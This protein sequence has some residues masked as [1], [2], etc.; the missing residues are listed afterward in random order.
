MIGQ[1]KHPCILAKQINVKSAGCL[2]NITWQ[3]PDRHSAFLK[4]WGY[5]T[6]FRRRTAGSSGG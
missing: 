5:H 6:H 3:S 1:M 4:F 2:Y